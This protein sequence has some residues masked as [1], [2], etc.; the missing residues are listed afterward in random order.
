MH[1]I[2]Q[3]FLK[4][5]EKEPE[6]ADDEEYEEE[7]KQLNYRY[8]AVEKAKQK[9]FG[10]NSYADNDSEDHK[11]EKSESDDEKEYAPR[12]KIVMNKTFNP[13]KS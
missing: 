12:R 10:Y 7:A 13:T 5:C 6:A 3:K 9:K 4:H 1:V 11:S 2:K 8:S